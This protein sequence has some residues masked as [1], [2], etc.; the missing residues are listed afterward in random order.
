MLSTLFRPLPVLLNMSRKN[1]SL[2]RMSSKT[3]SA[4]ETLSV[5]V[6]KEFVYHVMLNRPDKLNAMNRTMWLEIQKCFEELDEDENCRV[7]VLSG[8]G[9]LFTAGLD[10][11]DLMEMAPAFAAQEDVARKAKLIRKFIVTYQNSVTSL[12]ICKKP[13][14]AA[15]H[16][17]CVGGGI[18]I[19]TAADIRYCTKDAW[20]QVKEVDLGMAADV[21]ILQRLPKVIGS[22]SLARELC[23]TEVLD[24]AEQISK[25]SP[26][27][28][29][30]TKYS[31]VYGR[32]HSV[33][34]GLD[35]M[36]I[37]NQLMMQS[38]DF[39]QATMGQISKEPNVN[40]SKL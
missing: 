26:V 14:L 21:G 7:I 1:I 6:P 24:I 18:N 39:A 38:E 36:A 2:A 33:Q 4:Y 16:S 30:G 31:I 10:F 22:D 11:R 9:K 27:A 37:W 23:Y 13:V 8:A 5:S 15:V 19:I 17:A 32:D 3:K 20:F 40:F 35:Q 29:Q 28:I 12:E 34:E 25:K